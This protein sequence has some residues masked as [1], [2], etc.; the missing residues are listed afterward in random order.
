MHAARFTT[1][2]LTLVLATTPSAQDPE[3]TSGRPITPEQACF[4]VSRYAIDIRVDPESRSIT[5]SV[6]IDARLVAETD[7]LVLDLHDNLEVEKVW[8]QVEPEP[9]SIR[10]KHKQG[11]LEIN[12]KGHMPPVGSDFAVI[13][14]YGGEP[15]VAPN[16]PWDGGFVWEETPSGAPW[17]ATAN[18]MQGAD[19]WWPVKDQPDDE[20]DTMDIR[21]TVPKP[22]ICASNGK[23]MSVTDADKEGWHTFHWHVYFA[24]KRQRNDL[25]LNGRA[26]GQVSVSL[27]AEQDH[28]DVGVH[29]PHELGSVAQHA[30]AVVLDKAAVLRIPYVPAVGVVAEIRREK[31]PLSVGGQ[32]RFAAKCQDP[33]EHVLGRREDS[34]VA[35]QVPVR[36]WLFQRSAVVDVTD[37][38]VS[39]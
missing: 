9:R 32:D 30:P 5:G 34:S 1:L 19:L 36:V 21:V 27:V 28:D 33:P 22:L 38:P 12:V 39:D 37:V 14:E 18:Q 24:A 25:V 3:L 31:L 20:P 4:D 17:I 13:V 11:R 35:D 2:A 15:R 8:L 16:A 10:F 26:C 23:L 7:E 29:V 6:Q